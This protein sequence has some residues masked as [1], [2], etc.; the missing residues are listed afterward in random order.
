MPLTSS[1]VAYYGGTASGSLDLSAQT[2]VSALPGTIHITNE[3]ATVHIEFSF[4]TNLSVSFTNGGTVFTIVADGSFNGIINAVGRDN[5]AALYDL[6]Q[7]R[8]HLQL[9]HQRPQLE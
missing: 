9:E 7:R 8:R 3:V 6:E 2:T 1:G 5:G 4:T